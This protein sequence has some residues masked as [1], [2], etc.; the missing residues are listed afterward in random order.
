MRDLQPLRPDLDR[1][2][3]DSREVVDVLA[4]DRRVD[5]ESNAQLSRPSRDFALL[6]E[7]SLVGRDV[8]GRFRHNV[9]H[10]HL[11][12]I[13]ADP[14]QRLQ[15]LARQRHGRG[16]EI[17]VEPGLDRVRQYLLEIAPKGRFAAG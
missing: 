15:P 3:D 1:E 5:G 10:R 9:L 11:H 16:D 13:E 12:V 8:I 6:R 14:R 4:M 17:G 2:L 7:T